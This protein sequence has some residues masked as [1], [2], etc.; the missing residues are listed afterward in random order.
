MPV[1]STRGT[2]N[3]EPFNRAPMSSRRNASTTVAVDA[4]GISAAEPSELGVNLVHERPGGERRRGEHDRARR[5][6]RASLGF[7]R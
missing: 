2:T 5:Q 7:D 6:L 4:Y 1:C 3:P